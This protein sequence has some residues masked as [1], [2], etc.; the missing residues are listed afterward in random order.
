[1]DRE[2]RGALRTCS[3]RLPHHAARG[4]H[5]RRPDALR[6][7]WVPLQSP[8]RSR[9]QLRDG[10]AQGKHHVEP[11][12]QRTRLAQSLARLS[13][14][15]G[16]RAVPSAGCTGHGR[17]T[18]GTA[19]GGGTGRVLPPR[20][21]CRAGGAVSHAQAERPVPGCGAVQ[22]RGRRHPPRRVRDRR[23]LASDIRADGGTCRQR[24]PAPL[25]QGLPAWRRQSERPRRGHG[26]SPVRRDAHSLAGRVR[27]AGGAGMALDFRL[28]HGARKP[29]SLPGP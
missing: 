17:L 5:A 8:G 12:R 19:S 7:R 13:H 20:S 6:L 2:L 18:S 15:A 29:P 16:H 21:L 27:L 26:S 3:L 25:R 24:C 10:L 9:R 14:A 22:P 4:A 28:L 1:M 11:Y 23:F